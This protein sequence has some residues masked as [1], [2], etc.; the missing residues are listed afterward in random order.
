[1]AAVFAVGLRE[2]HQFDV[3]GVAPQVGEGLGQV[4]DFVFGQG[5]AQRDVG[6][7]QG[8][9]A[10]RLHAD[11]AHGLA[12]QRLEQ[13]LAVEAGVH[14]GFRHAVMQAIRRAGQH[15]VVEGLGA[16]QAALGR[17]GVAHA[18]F[19]AVHRRQAAVVGDI[20]GLA[21]PRGNRAQARDHQQRQALGRGVR[22]AGRAVVQQLGQ[23][24]LLFGRQGGVGADEVLVAGGYVGHRQA[25]V[26]Q[27]RQKAI[28]SKGGQDGGTR[29]M[30]N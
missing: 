1:M 29:Q 7:G 13:R 8:I 10:A 26:L 21:G 2:H 23:V 18:A 19:D 22:R 3:G 5:Q 28:T 4:F 6:F 17:D 16:Q 20:G 14:H 12:G 25:G 15:G 30:L 27:L 9:H 24:L 11:G